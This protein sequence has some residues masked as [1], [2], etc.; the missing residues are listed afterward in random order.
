MKYENAQ[1]LSEITKFAGM[2][3][4]DG[5][6]LPISPSSR[7]RTS[8]L[9]LE[10]VDGM[11]PATFSG[12]S[13]SCVAKLLSLYLQQIDCAQVWQ[14]WSSGTTQRREPSEEDDWLL[15]APKA[16]HKVLIQ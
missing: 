9:H 16:C 2:L 15:K 4:L 8:A 10:S 5:L 7:H 3:E 11:L 6:T 1:K 13:L 14:L 12:R